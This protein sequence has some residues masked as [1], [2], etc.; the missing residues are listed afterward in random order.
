MKPGSSV[1]PLPS[2]TDAP[3][4]TSRRLPMAAMRPPRTSTSRSPSICAPSKTRAPRMRM[5]LSCAGNEVATK[6]A[7]RQER[8][9]MSLVAV[10]IDKNTQTYGAWPLAF[11]LRSTGSHTRV[12]SAQ[13]LPGDSGARVRFCLHVFSKVVEDGLPS[14]PLKLRS[15]FVLRVERLL[16]EYAIGTRNK[17]H[18]YFPAIPHAVLYGLVRLD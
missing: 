12:R 17:L 11:R 13:I 6:S 7:S 15:I 18:F 1:L 3:P 8:S 14:L 9:V 5:V 10:G 16:Y 4:G 2:T